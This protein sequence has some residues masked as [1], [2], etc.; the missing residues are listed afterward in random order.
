MRL[1]LVLPGG[2]ARAGFGS[3][4]LL[5]PLA[6]LLAIAVAAVV[7]QACGGAQPGL[8]VPATVAPPSGPALG[9][10]EANAELL[11]NPEASPGVP[12]AF[13]TAARELT[14]LHPSYV[15]LL[16]DWAALQPDAD[17]PP[18]LAAA[19][20]GC[21]RRNGPCGAYAGLRAELEAIASQQR[22]P[23][24][25]G[26]FQVV[27]D[28]FGTPPWAARAPSGCERPGSSSFS[29][30]LSAGGLAGYRSLIGSLLELADREGV[31]ID[32]LSPWNEPN[33]PAFISPQRGSCP[34]DSPPVSAAVYARLARAMAAELRVHGGAPHLLLGELSGNLADSSFHT[35][36]ASFVAALP[37]DVICLGAVWSVHAYAAPAPSFADP[38]AALEAALGARGGCGR[39]ASIWVT[40]TGAGAHHPGAPRH[41]GSS[42]ERAGCEALA[43]QLI[44]WSRDPRVGAVFQ[45]TFRDDPAF[46]VGLVSADLSHPYRSYHLWLEWSRLRAAGEPPPLPGVGCS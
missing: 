33:E 40:E 18:E 12:P 30:P 43:E 10:T 19:V 28:I 34:V 11:W 38:V 39:S 4:R 24:G 27:I 26:A 8:R 37:A 17:R 1:R 2:R 14:A 42:E 45:Y 46:P 6:T 13:Q 29:R 20:S 23:G 36:L 7:L 31:A 9:L 5:R 3:L 44:R 15:R 21:A 32:W 16:V 35:G 41:G 25:A 22:R